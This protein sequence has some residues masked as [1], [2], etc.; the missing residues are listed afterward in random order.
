MPHH[1][2]KMLII[3]ASGLDNILTIL[4]ILLETC[5][6]AKTLDVLKKNR[7]KIPPKCINNQL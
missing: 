5:C 1:H 6:E 2:Y 4:R 3:V 7:S